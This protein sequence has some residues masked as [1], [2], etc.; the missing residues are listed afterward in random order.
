MPW[1]SPALSLEKQQVCWFSV[2]QS[3]HLL[4]SFPLRDD[5][6]V[7]VTENCV[8]LG[9]SPS[10]VTGNMSLKASQNLGIGADVPMAYADVLE[11]EEG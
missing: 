6:T 11:T 2:S 7:V 10:T 1:G 5:G 8:L 4:L 9:G 3:D